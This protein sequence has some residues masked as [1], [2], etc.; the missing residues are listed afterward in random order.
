MGVVLILLVFIIGVIWAVVMRT[1]N[2]EYSLYEVSYSVG[3]PCILSGF[4]I[5]LILAILLALKLSDGSDS[6]AIYYISGRAIKGGIDWMYVL[7][8]FF[9]G[10]SFVGML[11][12][13]VSAIPLKIT[14]L[15]SRQYR[16][17]RKALH[18]R[19][20]LLPIIK[21]KRVI[22]ILLSVFFG[23]FGAH[24]FYLRMWQ[25]GVAQI[26][27]IPVITVTFIFIIPS[28]SIEKD[29]SMNI[30]M[31]FLYVLYYLP[32]LAGLLFVMFKKEIVLNGCRI[33]IE[34]RQKK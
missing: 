21:R 1:K 34:H 7:V 33:V 12:T 28:L 32:W 22:A 20:D 9:L 10:G 23:Y 18:E 14:Y 26:L 24:W 25:L 4:T 31:S 15:L 13:W 2:G 11:I 17:Y 19:I 30:A 16:Q 5:G 27:Y 6:Q 29:I 3:K 8:T